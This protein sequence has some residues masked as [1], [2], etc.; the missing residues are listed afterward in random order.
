MMARSKSVSLAALSIPFLLPCRLDGIDVVSVPRISTTRND[1]DAKL[2]ANIT[3]YF[4]W[5]ALPT[6]LALYIPEILG[7]SHVPLLL[8]LE[9]AIPKERMAIVVQYFQYT[10]MSLPVVE[11]IK[12]RLPKDQH[13]EMNTLWLHYSEEN[14]RINQSMIQVVGNALTY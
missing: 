8:A 11:A 13:E 2:I 7:R 14:E 9:R 6:E 3:Y 4:D 12:T 10:N 5:F 1:F